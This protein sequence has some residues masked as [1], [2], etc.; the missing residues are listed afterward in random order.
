MFGYRWFLGQEYRSAQYAERSIMMERT[1]VSQLVVVD[2][3]IEPHHARISR[4][5]TKDRASFVSSLPE[6]E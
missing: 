3:Q 2:Y 1:V 4:Y 6:K 5:W